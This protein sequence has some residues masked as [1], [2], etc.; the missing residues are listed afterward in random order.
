[1]KIARFQT[2]LDRLL[3]ADFD[4]GL[5]PLPSGADTIRLKASSR[6]TPAAPSGRRVRGLPMTAAGASLCINCESAPSRTNRAPSLQAVLQTVRCLS[7][8]SLGCSVPRPLRRRLQHGLHVWE[9]QENFGT[10]CRGLTPRRTLKEPQP[11]K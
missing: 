11:K 2:Y 1:M 8:N 5:C 7:G 4:S 6:L 9:T 10:A 3:A